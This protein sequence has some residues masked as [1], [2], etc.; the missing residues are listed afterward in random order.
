M[1][2]EMLEK[3]LGWQPEVVQTVWVA[4]VSFT[5]GCVSAAKGIGPARAFI[6]WWKKK[7]PEQSKLCKSII[8]SLSDSAT[9]ESV[10]GQIKCEL[11]GF[12]LKVEKN[13]GVVA[14]FVDGREDTN[15]W[16]DLNKWDKAIVQAAVKDFRGREYYRKLNEDA[17]RLLI[18]RDKNGVK[19]APQVP[20]LSYE[21]YDGRN[22]RTG[23]E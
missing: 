8:A 15:R 1:I 17:A 6:R 20:G 4:A 13:Y 12:T 22:V 5:T 9:R 2:L 11:R 23:V 3:Y 10:G 14:I 16:D 19:V 7:P 18:Y 21:N